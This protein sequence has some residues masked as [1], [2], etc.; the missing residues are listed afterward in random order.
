[1]LFPLPRTLFH[2]LPLAHTLF[3]QVL[4]TFLQK[5]LDSQAGS[6]PRL[7]LPGSPSQLCLAG[8]TTVW[9]QVCLPHWAEAVLGHCHVPNMEPGTQVPGV[10]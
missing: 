8:F 9:E 5:P 7:R 3:L 1:M 10:Q 4:Y 2:L 6:V